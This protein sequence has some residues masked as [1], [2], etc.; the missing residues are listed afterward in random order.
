MSDDKDTEIAR[1]TEERDIA[2]A[3]ALGW[4]IEAERRGKALNRVIAIDRECPTWWDDPVQGVGAIARAAL[5]TIPCATCG[6]TGAIQVGTEQPSGEGGAA[7][8]VADCPTCSGT[9]K[10]M[11][12]VRTWLEILCAAA[13]AAGDAAASGIGS[14]ADCAIVVREAITEALAALPAPP[15]DALREHDE[16]LVRRA[17][18]GA[19]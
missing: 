8:T 4:A 13:M 7:W 10:A 11:A 14:R 9:G 16:A 6:G 18:E 3:D 1:L 15:A 2:R 17:K 5:A 19:P 12:D